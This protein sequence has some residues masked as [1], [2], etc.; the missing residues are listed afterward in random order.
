MKIYEKNCHYIRYPLSVFDS[1][2]WDAVNV[3][4]NEY[5][6]EVKIITLCCD[7]YEIET[8]L[9]FLRLIFYILMPMMRTSSVCSL[10][11]HR[12]WK[13]SLISCCCSSIVNILFSSSPSISCGFCRSFNNILN[14]FDSIF[15]SW[16]QPNWSA[17]PS[18]PRYMVLPGF[19]SI[20]WLL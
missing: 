8:L 14:L 11:P 6:C 20:W 18:E 13:N 10:S 12:S 19:T 4:S 3:Q 16:G 7:K 9:W 2:N 15:L 17:Y 5:I 1:K